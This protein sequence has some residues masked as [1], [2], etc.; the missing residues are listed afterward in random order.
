MT[1][2]P[3]GRLGQWFSFDDGCDDLSVDDERGDSATHGNSQHDVR[4]CLHGNLLG[5]SCIWGHSTPC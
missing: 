1:D 2:M 5:I 3:C 4:K